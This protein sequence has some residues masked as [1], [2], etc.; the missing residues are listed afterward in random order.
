MFKKLIGFCLVLCFSVSFSMTVFA[1]DELAVNQGTIDREYFLETFLEAAKQ[2]ILEFGITGEQYYAFAQRA[3]LTAGQV[4]E[5]LGIDS[6]AFSVFD[7]DILETLTDYEIDE[8][9]SPYREIINLLNHRYGATLIL[10]YLYQMPYWGSPDAV[11]ENFIRLLSGESTFDDWFYVAWQNA[12][13]NMQFRT[14]HV[15]NVMT[16]KR[17]VGGLPSQGYVEIGPFGGIIFSNRASIIFTGVHNNTPYELVC[18][19]H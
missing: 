6:Q 2:T 15:S 5:M 12:G 16:V 10:P 17:F 7:R 13:L 18:A 19:F 9:M 4:Q 11:R 3:L 8:L 1:G 14:H